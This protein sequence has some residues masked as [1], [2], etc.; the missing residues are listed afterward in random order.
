VIQILIDRILYEL[1][2]PRIVV[3]DSL[4]RDE[5]LGLVSA[6]LDIDRGSLAGWKVSDLADGNFLVRPAGKVAGE[7]SPSSTYPL[8]QAVPGR[9][10]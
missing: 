10:S 8:F 3:R 1:H 9:V 5:I 7:Q 4:A 6:Y 2:D